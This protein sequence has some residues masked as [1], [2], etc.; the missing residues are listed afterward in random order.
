METESLCVPMIIRGDILG[1]IHI[2]NREQ[3]DDSRGDQDKRGLEHKQGLALTI[4]EHLAI[5]LANMNL[6]ESLLQSIL[7]PL[8]GLYNRR[9]LYK[10]L[11]REY[12][13]LK[14]HDYSVRIIMLDVDHFKKFND[15]YEHECGDC[16]PA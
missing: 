12:H 4:A 6:R 3:I 10:S 8:T 5:A 2:R 15:T 16:R 11:R 9:F 14:R 1:M 13:S 7:D